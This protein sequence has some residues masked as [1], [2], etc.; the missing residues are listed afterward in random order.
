MNSGCKVFVIFKRFIINSVNAMPNI[1]W[2]L[3]QQFWLIVFYKM[4]QAKAKN[5]LSH[6]DFIEIHSNP[7]LAAE[8]ANLVYIANAKNGIARK[9]RGKGFIYILQNSAV[10]DKAVIERIKKL[11]IPPA[12]ENVWICHLEN[13]HLQAT[14]FD[15]RKRKQYRYHALWN[16]LRN[17][18]KFHHLLEFGRALPQLR[19]Q[20]EKD[21]AQ[22]EITESK[23]IATVISVMERTYIRIGNETYEKEN[24]SFGL[25]TLKDRHVNINGDTIIFSFNGKKNVH[26]NISLKNKKLAKAVKDC[27]DI[28]GKELFQYYDENKER[29]SIDSG[30]VNNYIKQ[31]AGGNFSAKDFRTWAASLNILHSFAAME[32]AID[33]KQRKMNVL[34]ALDNVSVRLGN[35]RTVCK[36]YYV[37]PGIIELYEQDKLKDYLSQLNKIEEPDNKS[38][39]TIAEQLL[40]RVLSFRREKSIMAFSVSLDD[41]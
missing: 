32:D 30:M 16:Y 28:P 22:K 2:V 31:A 6:K 19:L 24:G 14:G 36:K 5:K 17:E 37:H 39:L 9:R 10:K 3:W 27:K 25:T 29:K 21:M 26:H 41:K 4:K 13:G 20:L 7:Q 12:W 8:A 1:K 35:T 18:T 40:M 38:G 11:A 23:V 15:A 33:E 34:Q